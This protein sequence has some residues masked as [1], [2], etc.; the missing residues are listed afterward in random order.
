MY[1]LLNPDDYFQTIIKYI[2]S[3]KSCIYLSA[4]YLGSDSLKCQQLT[5]A[6]KTSLSKEINLHIYL[7][8]DHSRALRKNTSIVDI[9]NDIK[10]L[11]PDRF[12]VYLYKMPQLSKFYFDMPSPFNEVIAV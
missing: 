8:F 2:G 1:I 6:L 10:L 7:V 12:H 9:L 5:D 4:L 3:S 11:Y